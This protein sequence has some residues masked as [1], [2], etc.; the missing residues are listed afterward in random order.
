MSV[1][2][3]CRVGPGHRSSDKHE[4]DKRTAQRHARLMFSRGRAAHRSGRSDT[5]TKGR[6]EPHGEMSRAHVGPLRSSLTEPLQPVVWI[7]RLA[8]DCIGGDAAD[9]RAKRVAIGAD[10]VEEPLQPG[11]LA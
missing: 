4:Q 6:Y 10:R 8:T 2:G 1:V 11:R 9:D 5:T 7:D 3:H